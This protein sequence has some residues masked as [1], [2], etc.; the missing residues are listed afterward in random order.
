MS[1]HGVVTRLLSPQTQGDGDSVVSKRRKAVKRDSPHHRISRQKIGKFSV[2]HAIQKQ[3]DGMLKMVEGVKSG[4]G[5]EREVR[6]A[7]RM[8]FQ[9][10]HG[11]CKMILFQYSD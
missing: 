4:G 2:D 10:Q 8:D 6:H 5:T 3:Q 7:A 9:L 1:G 11:R